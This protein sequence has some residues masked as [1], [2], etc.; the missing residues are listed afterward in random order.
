MGAVT[1]GMS[2]RLMAMPIRLEMTA[3]ET[4]LTLAGVVARVPRKYRSTTTSPRRL[5]RRLRRRGRSA[6]ALIAASNATP[7]ETSLRGV[8]L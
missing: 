1:P 6:A 7:E 2:L 8:W 5:T 3:F 4:D